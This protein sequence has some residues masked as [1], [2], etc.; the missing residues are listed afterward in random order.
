MIAQ[1]VSNFAQGAG[2]WRMRGGGRISRGGPDICC[3]IVMRR[4]VRAIF[5]T[6]TAVLLIGFLLV[7]RLGFGFN[8]RYLEVLFDSS[9]VVVAIFVDPPN[10]IGTVTY[11]PDH[12]DVVLM[13]ES[14]KS[15]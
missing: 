11:T 14:I 5:W 2:G 15:D 6:S 12:A 1:M 3:G 8:T 9:N 13:P 7:Q 10:W 4:F